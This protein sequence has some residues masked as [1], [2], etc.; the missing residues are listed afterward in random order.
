MYQA[1]LNTVHSAKSRRIHHHHHHHLFRS[2]AVNNSAIQ[3]EN[4][5]AEQDTPDSDELVQWP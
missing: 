4:L 5:E 1:R 3:K 2:V